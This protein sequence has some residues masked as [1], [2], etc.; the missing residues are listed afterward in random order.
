MEVNQP[1]AKSTDA[2]H[3]RP[4]RKQAQLQG[5]SALIGEIDQPLLQSQQEK[6]KLSGSALDRSLLTDAPALGAACWLAIPN[7]PGHMQP[8]A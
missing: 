5:S 3:R 6:H 8:V 4:A 7:E 2:Y 1:F